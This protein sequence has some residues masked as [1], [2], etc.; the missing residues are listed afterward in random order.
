MNIKQLIINDLSTLL[1]NNVIPG[2]TDSLQFIVG[3]P[4]VTNSSKFSI[5]VPRTAEQPWYVT[6]FEEYIPVAVNSL[7]GSYL[8]QTA[9]TALALDG[10]MSFLVPFE[11]VVNGNTYGQDEVL[12]ILF[13]L[14]ETL[15][16]RVVS[17]GGYRVSYSIGVPD[18]EDSLIINDRKYVV[19]NLQFSTIASKN[20]FTAHDVKVY[21]TFPDTTP[22]E[23][24][25]P[26]IAYAPIKSRDTVTV[27]TQGDNTATSI[28]KNTV[29]TAN[30]G[31]FLTNDTETYNGT[32]AMTIELLRMLE[33]NNSAQNKVLG[34][35]LV[36]PLTVVVDNEPVDYEVTKQVI[37]TNLQPTFTKDSL[38]SITITVEEVY[39]EVI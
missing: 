32:T 4:S 8:P 22:W 6:N 19:Y 5:E 17:L 20:S 34:L 23:V 3:K 2:T 14:I 12:E 13:E 28:V 21:L 18:Y 10:D 30:L 16:G 11:F 39:N 24:E 36:Y 35:R 25:V 37:I 38:A 29:W 31:L 15:P 7:N 33:E 26:L 1:N 9:F 27:Q